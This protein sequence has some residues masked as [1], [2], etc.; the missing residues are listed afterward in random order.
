M[1]FAKAAA[2]NQKRRKFAYEVYGKVE[3]PCKSARSENNDVRDV[4]R[5]FV[6]QSGLGR[7][8]H[9]V[10]NHGSLLNSE[11]PPKHL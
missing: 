6:S 5:Q 8:P 2:R 10:Q 9:P 1:S 11:S 3:H 7:Y 4:T